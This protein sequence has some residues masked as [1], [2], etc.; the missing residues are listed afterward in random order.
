GRQPLAYRGDSSDPTHPDVRTL[1][2]EALRVFRSRVVNPRW[3]S[4][5]QRH[6][7]R[8]GLEMV[9]TVDSLFGFAAT[10]GIC[11]DWMFETVAENY[12]MGA[13]REFLERFTPWA[14]N[15][16]AERLLEAEQRQLWRARADTLD[17]LRSV[18][19][20][21]EATIEEHAP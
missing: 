21:S 19:L 16:I 9:T 10:A 6:G 12:P 14:L 13:A 20:A 5:I 7:Y 17:A 3:L 2:A 18:L 8:G 15:A 4:G 1:K 11:T